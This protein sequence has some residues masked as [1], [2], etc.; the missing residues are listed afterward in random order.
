MAARSA[1]ADAEL[2]G[3]AARF[4]SNPVVGDKNMMMDMSA[5][6]TGMM[7]GAGVYHLIIVVFALLGSAACV[8]YLR[9]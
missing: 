9:S 3:L 8:K 5:L 1:P 7:I 6:P 2:A 4:G